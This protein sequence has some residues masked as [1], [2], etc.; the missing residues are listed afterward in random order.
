LCSQVSEDISDAHINILSAPAVGNQAA[1]EGN[2]DVVVSEEISVTHPD[3]SIPPVIE[4]QEVQSN[5][6]SSVSEDISDA[7]SDVLTPVRGGWTSFASQS[8]GGSS[9]VPEQKEHTA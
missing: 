1:S 3:T 6:N 5:Q 9:N 8:E 7:H 2:Q 4:D